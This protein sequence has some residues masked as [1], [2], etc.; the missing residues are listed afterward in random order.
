MIILIKNGHVVDPAN[1]IDG[2][3]DMLIA[4]GVIKNVSQR[5]ELKALYA[6]VS[7]IS[8]G[9]YMVAESLQ[10]SIK[11]ELRVIDATGKYI[12]PGL[13]DL[14]VHLR[15]PGFEYKETIET[16]ALAA[17]HGGVTTICPMPNTNPVIDSP[18]LVKQELEIAKKAVVNICPIGAVTLGQNGKELADIKGMKEAGAV[19]VSEDGKSVMNTA[20]YMEGLKAA[21]EAGIPVFAHCED[22]NLVRGGV[23]N[24][25]EK[26]RELG[27]NGITN[28]VEDVIVARD[29]I[30]SNEAGNHIH[31]CHC[32]TELSVS[33]VKWAKREGMDVSAEVCPHHFTLSDSDI[34][35]DDAN[36]KMN[37][38]LRSKDDVMALKA[39]LMAGTMEV[40]S[41]DH[42]P[43][44]KEEKEKS[45]KNSP[46][47]IT[48][49][50]TSFALSVTELVKAGIL[51]MKELVNRMST[52]PASIINIDRGTLGVGKVA[53]VII[54]DVDE[55]Y[56][57]DKETFL[58]KGKNTPFDGKKV[59]G[60]V[61]YTIVNGDIV[62]E[63]KE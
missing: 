44:S 30:M 23:M 57:I 28:S 26:S 17:A 3:A 4:D 54:T 35:G 38:P 42:A 43:H 7:E 20:V 52:T 46:F 29:I 61:L 36:F 40:I 33:L 1:D 27:F 24:E 60:K 32:S 5:I 56:I 50:E 8:E 16:G 12:L 10:S 53:D 6:E 14:H 49:L 41:T 11:E 62:W 31:L 59:Y 9:K 21:K 39:G 13:V 15:E 55:P 18:E 25:G 47:G 63:E 58:S 19:A 51:T 22:I 48:G 2:V 45:I 34:P 37:P